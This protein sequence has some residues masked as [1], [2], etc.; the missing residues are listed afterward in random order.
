MYYDIISG[1]LRFFFQVI[2]QYWKKRNQ[3][4]SNLLDEDCGNWP[5][6]SDFYCK[7][8]Q[9]MESFTTHKFLIL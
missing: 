2:H 8:N 6:N 9:D 3:L 1:M 5:G 7:C 4:K